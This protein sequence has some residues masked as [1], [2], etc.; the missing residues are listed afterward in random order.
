MYDDFDDLKDN[1]PAEIKAD[2]AI[3]IVHGDVE[4]VAAV[5]PA[6]EN[7]EFRLHLTQE[8]SDFWEKEVRTR[9]GNNVPEDGFAIEI[10]VDSYT[11][12][13]M[14]S[15]L[16]LDLRAY[17]GTEGIGDLAWQ[18]FDD[19]KLERRFAAEIGARVPI[20]LGAITDATGVHC[21]VEVTEVEEMR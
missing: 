7:G 6:T 4:R 9:G 5:W 8:V 21:E 18:V 19:D 16:Y 17:C 1:C 2:I 11:D 13:E 10:V 12:E 15:T 3:D 20:L 14:G